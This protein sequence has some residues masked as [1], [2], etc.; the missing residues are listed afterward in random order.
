MIAV[1]ERRGEG[2]KSLSHMVRLKACIV[3]YAGEF[4]ILGVVNDALEA[5]D[6]LPMVG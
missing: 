6:T 2:G 4:V 1:S 5:L 3:N